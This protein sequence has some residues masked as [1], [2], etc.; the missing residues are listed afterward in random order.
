[1]LSSKDSRRSFPK[2]W[3]KSQTVFSEEKLLWG[4]AFVL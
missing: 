1:M 3:D 4:M 2:K